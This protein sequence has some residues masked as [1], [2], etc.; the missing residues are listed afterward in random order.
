MYLVMIE[1]TTAYYRKK[2]KPFRMHTKRL[3]L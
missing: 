3:L 2:E 1:A